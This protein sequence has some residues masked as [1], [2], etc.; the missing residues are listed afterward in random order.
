LNAS[1]I[2]RFLREEER[3]KDLGDDRSRRRSCAMDAP[4]TIRDE[5]QNVPASSWKVVPL[6]L[7]SGGDLNVSL[8]V[9]RGNPLDTS[10]SRQAINW[11][12]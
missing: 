12:S 4:V 1:E 8:Q 2:V 3:R 7:L 9:V 5:V 11:T 6:T 10:S